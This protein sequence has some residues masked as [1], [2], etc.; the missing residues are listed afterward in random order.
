MIEKKIVSTLV[1]EH[2]QGSENWLV[3][4]SVTPENHITVEIDN[5]NGVS[6]DDCAKLSTF[7]ENNLDREKEDYELEVGSAGITTPFKIRRQYVKNIGNEV[8]MMLLTGEKLTGILKE[9]DETGAT[10][11]IEK[12]VKPESS[13]RK[14][15]VTQDITY[16]YV[17]I[18]YTKNIIIF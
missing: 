14:I 17:K 6:I 18:K 1:E 11:T 8:E 15:T 9:A 3:E 5:D 10:L 4:V 2:L 7:I 16:P 13:K 12:Q